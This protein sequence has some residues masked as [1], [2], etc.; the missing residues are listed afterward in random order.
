MPPD[1]QT[2]QRR[3]LLVFLFLIIPS[4]V[5]SLFVV[6]AGAIGFVATA[7]AT[8][9]RDLSLVSLIALFLWRNAESPEQIGWD[10]KNANREIALGVLLYVPFAF[11]VGAIA[12]VFQAAGLKSP[13][14]QLPK[15]LTAHGTVQ[16]GL[17]L[18]LVMIVAITEE[19]IFR[20]YLI[21]RFAEATK[22]STAAVI[23]SA[24]VF[25]MGHGYE[26]SAGVATVGVM[27]VL[28]G[29]VYLWRRNLV[30]AI[31]MHFLQDFIGI[32]LAPLYLHH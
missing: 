29:I 3:E 20:G 18:L 9:F 21:L 31:I 26:G 4:M 22:S 11:G 12:R 6:H 17:A 15:F 19:V 2:V 1:L 14:T 10:W 7:I 23:L 32:V 13:S 8:I 27:G 30:A 5:L 28:L 24:I 16:L 25:S